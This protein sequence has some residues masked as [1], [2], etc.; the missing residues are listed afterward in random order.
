MKGL[1][2]RG[3][4]DESNFSVT[5]MVI[6]SDELVF[7][8]A[9]ATGLKRNSGLCGENI[10]RDLITSIHDDAIGMFVFADGLTVNF[11]RLKDALEGNLK[12]DRFIPMFGGTSANNRKMIRTI[13]AVK[14]NMHSHVVCDRLFSSSAPF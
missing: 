6:Q 1:F 5:T 10:A 4:A 11:D 12:P 14:H 9:W 7:K 13:C 2:P 8:N 3:E